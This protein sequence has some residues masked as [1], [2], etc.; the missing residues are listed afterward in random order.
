M[1]WL[2]NVVLA[3]GL[4]ATAS[5][6]AAPGAKEAQVTG[7]IEHA[8][9]MESRYE[10]PFGQLQAV[11][12]QESR[13]RNVPG[14]AGEIGVCQIKPSTV[15]LVAGGNPYALTRTV[16]ALG[17]QG[18]YVSAIQAVLTKEVDDEL[19]VDGTF[20]V[21]TDSA[22]R[23]YQYDNGLK[24]DGIVGPKTWGQLFPAAPFPGKTI[25][26]ALWN[27]KENIEW[28]AKIFVYIRDHCGL[29]GLSATA[30]YN[31]GCGH[32]VVRYMRQVNKRLERIIN[33]NTIS[34]VDIGRLAFG[35][36]GAINR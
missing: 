8:A 3:F 15:A 1:R 4:V 2:L 32:P 30:A 9:L 17:S 35:S 20:G 5:T 11:C 29:T 34:N 16:Y 18:S 19:V 13:W 24:V 27:P 25:T 28:A 23:L 21:H 10:L 33:E 22:V 26:T 7:L 36:S 31:G 6:F 14:Q 12:E